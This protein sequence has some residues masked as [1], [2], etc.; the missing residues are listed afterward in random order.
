[1]AEKSIRISD[2]ASGLRLATRDAYALDGESNARVIPLYDFAAG[3][4]MS[5]LGPAARG[6]SSWLAAADSFDLTALPSELLNWLID[7]GDGSVLTVA[8]EQ[9]VSGGTATVTPVLFDAQ[10]PPN[11]VGVL[12]PKTFIQTSAFRMGASSGHYKLPVAA[13]DV[14]GAHKVGLHLSGITGTSNG[15]RLFAWIDGVEVSR[16]DP[17]FRYNSLLL[18][19]NG[20]NN[21][22]IFPDYSPNNV[23][24]TRAGT[25]ITSEAQSKFG[26]SSAYFNNESTPLTGTTGVLAFGTGDFTIECWVYEQSTTSYPYFIGN[27][28][29]NQ[30]GNLSFNNSHLAYGGRVVL[31]CYVSTAWQ[32]ADSGFNLTDNVWTHIAVTRRNGT[33]RFFKDGILSNSFTGNTWNFAPANNAYSIGNTFTGYINDLRVTAGVARY[34][35]N[36]TPPTSAHPITERAG[37]DPHFWRVPLLLHCNGANNG[38][39][40]PD[41]SRSPKVTTRYGD[42]KT[43]TSESKFGGSCAYFDGTGDYIQYADSGDWHFGVSPFT[44][45]WWAKKANATGYYMIISHIS[46]GYYGFQ[47]YHNTPGFTLSAYNNNNGVSIGATCTQDTNWHHYAV[48]GDGTTV[49]LFQDGVVVGSGNQPNIGNASAVMRVGIDWDA[50]SSPFNGYLQD[51]RITK[52]AARYTSEFTPPTAPFPSY[53]E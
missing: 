43:V 25:T 24:L 33:I 28:T 42:T 14:S 44:I 50:S 15:V 20:A 7:V 36:F 48:C 22:T 53:R 35:A 37:Q 32:F 23:V 41:S 13:W 29:P 47:V 2:D 3:K 5:P 46:A 11:V 6:L 8:V 4:F 1:M 10:S 38:V 18:P 19:M 49:R 21:G 9:T 12:D 52:G 34:T 26:G 27:T 51:L 17:Y 30:N 31:A 39:A 45:E 16:L 40:F